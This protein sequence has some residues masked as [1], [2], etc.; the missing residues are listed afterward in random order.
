MGGIRRALISVSDKEGVIAFAQGLAHHHVEL[1]STGGTARLLREAGLAVIEVA[2]YTGFPEMLEGR[3]KTLHPEIHGGLLARRDDPKHEEDMRQQGI[4]PIDLLCVNLYPFEATIAQPD[5]RLEDAIEQI[6][7]GGP[8]ML[9]AGAKNWQGVT[10]VV[11][12]ADYEA[13]LREMEQSRGG[14]GAKLRFQLAAKVFAHTARYDGLIANHLSRHLDNLEE[15]DDFPRILTLQLEQQQTLRYGENPHQRAAFY[16]DAS[17]SG[18]AQAQQLQGKE[19]SY[20]NLSDSDAAINLVREFAEPACAIIK[21]G[22]PCGTAIGQDIADAFARAWSAD[23]VSAFG[24]VIACNRPITAALAQVM[25]ESFI[26]VILAPQVEAE[27]ATTLA[28]KKNLRVLA[29]GGLETQQQAAGWDLK[30][31]RGGLLLQDFDDLVEDETLWR[32]V[33]ERQPTAE[34]RRDLRFAWKVAKHVR[35]NAIVYAAAGR[36]LGVGAGQ[37]SRVDA[38]RCG[39]AKAEEL[40]FSLQGA[41]LASDAFFPFRD[42]VDAAG[43][44]G[45]KAIIQPGGSIRDEEVIASANEQGI[46]MIFTGVRHFRHG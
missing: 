8:T 11:D 28:R 25:S 2:D 7:I 16:A 32:V 23:P 15:P 24:S 30:R 39:A 46:A 41:A 42:G 35:S 5:V 13:V 37:M 26:E 10:V 1:L 38:A 12:P 18:L 22:N 6:D 36:T 21:H 45:V 44:T 17:P 33:S 31:V 19:L 9:R 43:A 20:N 29:Y 3:L 34:E 40:G 14:V 4:P 27:A